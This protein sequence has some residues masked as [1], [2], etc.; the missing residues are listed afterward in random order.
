MNTLG[1]VVEYNPFHNGHLYH[2]TQ[3][4]KKV[5]ATHTLAVMSGDFV[6]RGTP[7][8]TD[9][10]VRT[11]M[12][13][14]AGVN[15]V[16][17]LPAIYAM[18]DAGGFATGSVKLLDRTR[19]CTNLVFGS[20][21]NDIGA[22]KYLAKVMVENEYALS[23]MEEK[24]VKEGFSHPN[25]RKYAFRDFLNNR[26]MD[27]D[28]RQH[29]IE[30]LARS[31][32][33]LGLEYLKA[34]KIIRSEIEPDC[35][36]RTGSDYN[37]ASLIENFSSATAIRKAFQM[38]KAEEIKN[39]VPPHVWETLLTLE[40][41]L[42]LPNLENFE[43]TLINKL[44]AL[45]RDHL[46]QFYGFTEGLDLRF[47]KA[48]MISRN[49]EELLQRVKSKRF[50]YT[51]LQR[52]L[53]YFLFEITKTDIADSE[54]F[55]PQYIRILGFD[56]KGQELLSAMRDRATIPVI[57]T[58]SIYNKTYSKYER[59]YETREEETPGEKPYYS[60]YEMFKKQLAFDFR[61]ADYYTTLQCGFLPDALMDIK[62][63]PLIIQ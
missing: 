47:L 29:I 4:I 25:A 3:S 1:I 33:I 37:N 48:A 6:Q 63:K 61:C 40:E 12:A 57:S 30:I 10:W 49:L 44:R 27:D 60:N 56:E 21:S 45:T 19:I 39:N 15:L 17:E 53:L 22:L 35:I 28:Q 36:G 32:D 26:S 42:K 7:A 8:F 14:D 31:N 55:G 11:K 34:L 51:R 20:E 16:V 2:L 41:K 58:P 50:T 13:L 59:R 38:K 62:R 43:I 9:K 18:Q 54:E 5:N 24:Y 23:E 52:L 46:Q